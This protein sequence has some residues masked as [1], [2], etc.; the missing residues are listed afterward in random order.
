[1]YRWTGITDENGLQ[2]AIDEAV[3]S[4]K[5]QV[6]EAG[7]RLV[8]T[9]AAGSGV[10]TVSISAGDDSGALAALG[11][12]SSD[13]LQSYLN[14]SDTL[15]EIASSLNNPFQFNSD[16]N[17]GLTING[18]QF[19]FAQNA[20]LSEMMDEINASDA[21]VTMRYSAV[22]DRFTLTSDTSGAGNRISLSESGS[23]FLDGVGL[24]VYTAGVTL[25]RQ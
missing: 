1:M 21:G 23:T 20:T 2:N 12:S 25:W 8:L 6:S 22:N 7:G 11:F 19:S 15:A 24:T 5:I 14:T 16:G 18:V 10:G 17:I 13:N 3:G 4:G 9:K